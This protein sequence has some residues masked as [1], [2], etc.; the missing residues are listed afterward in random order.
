MQDE[1][2]EGGLGGGELTDSIDNELDSPTIDDAPPTEESSGSVEDDVK[3]ALNQLK[4][5][6]DAPADTDLEEGEKP[7]LLKNKAEEPEPEK[8][9]EPQFKAQEN[10]IPK[11][12]RPPQR[13]TLE[14]KELFNKLPKKMKGV[15][16]EAINQLESDYAEKMS[17]V[18]TKLRENDAINEVIGRY[19]NKW[20]GSYGMTPSQV[21]SSLAAAQDRLTDPDKEN[22]KE[23]YAE[24]FLKSGLTA[25][26]F[27]D[28]LQG[29][30]VNIPQPQNN[31]QP[32][33]TEQ[34]R[35]R[36]NWIDTQISATFN[37][38]KDSIADEVRSVREMVGPNG[39]Y[40]YP[41]LHDNQYL[42]QRVKP[43]VSAI[44]SATPGI[45]YGEAV[46]RA[47]TTLEGD[48]SV[49]QS[50]LPVANSNVGRIVRSSP[51]MM[52]SGVPR[53]SA[54]PRADEVPD[55]IEASVRMSMEQLQRGGS[56]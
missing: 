39:N 11:E 43:L 56:F 37:N 49:G 10:V 38:L 32:V 47:Y 5:T 23:A 54:R 2:Q 19:M 6:Q 42:L 21:F 36:Q 18:N 40:L 33:L 22:R 4:S 14:Q 7:A 24:L 16:K 15:F 53:T 25:Q 13:L 50:R 17:F 1:R 26:D 52:G 46:K 9:E 31:S 20:G 45:S 48:T 30:G 3:D 8:E 41:K 51:T 35:V 27:V 28:I 55:N 29:T 12:L 44:V 34:D